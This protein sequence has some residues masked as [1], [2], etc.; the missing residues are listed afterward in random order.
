[1]V[2]AI[3]MDSEGT[4]KN[5]K[6]EIEMETVNIINDIEQK[7]VPVVITTGLPRFISNKIANRVGANSYLI[8]SNGADIFD[9]KRNKSIKEIYINKEFLKK[10]YEESK[11]DYNIIL[12]VGIFEYA[13]SSNEYNLNTHPINNIDNI[14]ENIFQCHISQ[15]NIY[16]QKLFDLKEEIMNDK[17][18]F[19]RKNLGKELYEKCLNFDINFMTKEELNII[20]RALSFQKLLMLKNKILKYKEIVSLGNQSIDFTNFQIKGETPWFSFN[21]SGVSKGNAIKTVCNYLKIDAK[22]TIGIGNDYN[23]KTII[24]TVGE[25]YCPDD[26]RSFIKEKTN[27]TYTLGEIGKVLKKIYERI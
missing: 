23:D 7:G 11:N 12:G 17:S 2:K 16:I 10:I 19:L 4:L 3:F 9:L 25:F 27:N 13:N 1:M 8:S 22:D 6:N 15:R 5:K 14:K 18:F 26:A 24:D 21:A 20:A